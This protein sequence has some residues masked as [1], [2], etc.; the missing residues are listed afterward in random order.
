MNSMRTVLTAI[1]VLAVTLTAANAHALGSAGILVGNG[2][3]D[4][5]NIGVGARAGVSLPLLPL[6]VGGTFVYHLGKTETTA[7][8]DV[9]TRIF[10]LGPEAGYETGFFP[11]SIRPYLGLGYA[12][13]SASVPDV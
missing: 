3:K 8:G 12:S 13:I 10:Y 1:A 4:G 9:T 6:Y 2:F 5:Y 7:I 11:L